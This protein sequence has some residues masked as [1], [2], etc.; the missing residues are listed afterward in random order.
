METCTPR[1]VLVVGD[2]DVRTTY[3]DWLL[4]GGFEVAEAVDG[5]D[6]KTATVLDLPDLVLTEARLSGPVALIDLCMY[7]DARG[8]RVIVA[9]SS[10]DDRGGAA[11]GCDRPVLRRPTARSLCQEVRRVLK[12]DEPRPE[13]DA[14]G[15][16]SQAPDPAGL[17]QDRDLP[18]DT[19][20]A[21][22]GKP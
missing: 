4:A 11:P 16:G 19:P 12:S 10:A 6:A 21:R 17:D 18:L 20:A 2:G 5:E 8:V 7:F 13:D 15:A 22:P 1:L 14:V 9:D 3:C